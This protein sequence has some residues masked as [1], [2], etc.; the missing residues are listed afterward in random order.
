MGFVKRIY[1][2]ISFGVCTFL[3]FQE[4]LNADLSW[5]FK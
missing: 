3:L 4:Y 5:I 1:T 2:H